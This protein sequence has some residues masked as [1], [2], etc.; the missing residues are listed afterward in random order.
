M[1]SDHGLFVEH[2]LANLLRYESDVNS[3]VVA[4]VPWFPA[5]LGKHGKYG[6]YASISRIENR[7]GIE[8]LHPR[9]P[10]IPKV[11]MTIAPLLIAR[12]CLRAMRKIVADGWDFD[13]IDAHYFYPDGVAAIML[14]KWLNRPVV[15]TARGTDI[16]LIPRYRFPRRLI[17]WA[18]RECNGMITVCEAL[19][20][21]LVDLGA[22]ADRIVT[23]RNGVDLDL[24]A[25]EDRV[26]ARRRIGLHE[27]QT[28]LLSVGHLVERKGHHIVIDAL[29]RLDQN[30]TLLVV[31]DGEEKEA[32]EQQAISLGVKNRVRFCGSVLQ[33]ELPSYYSAADALVLASSREGMANVLLESIAC[34]TPVA[35]TKIW[36]T[37]EVI[38]DGISGR[39]IERRDAESAAK[40]IAELLRNPLSTSD[41][42]RFAEGFSWESTSKGQFDVFRNAIG[43]QHA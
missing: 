14:G 1:Q 35:A 20:E 28:I 37:P 12:S 8:I 25:P 27:N 4:P 9:F 16:N 19:R 2:R 42:R 24:F 33:R 18:A 11:G 41:I 5:L 17:Q 7:R 34:G 31:G 38:R 26:E 36:G 13:L 3:K 10:V 43:T 40:A 23:L 21:S 29:P 15:I 32:L 39:L 6:K 22:N 30:T